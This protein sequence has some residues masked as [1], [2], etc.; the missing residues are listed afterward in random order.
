MTYLGITL[1]VKASIGILSLAYRTRTAPDNIIITIV[2]RFG[3]V[4]RICAANV[5]A[6]PLHFA[7]PPLAIVM[8]V[9]V[10]AVQS[11]AVS[12]VAAVTGWRA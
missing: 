1:A 12:V 5:A 9:G 2:E 6:F 4:T 7:V 8:R 10:V 11:A 3:L